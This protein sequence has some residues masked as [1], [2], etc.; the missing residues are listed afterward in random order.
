M[1][2]F[3]AIVVNATPTADLPSVVPARRV[4]L[5]ESNVRNAWTIDQQAAH[6]IGEMGDLPFEQRAIDLNWLF[7]T[8][9]GSFATDDAL[10]ECC[11]RGVIPWWEPSPGHRRPYS[12]RSFGSMLDKVGK[13]CQHIGGVRYVWCE[14]GSD[15]AGRLTNEGLGN[16]FFRVWESPLFR[17][18]APQRM[19]DVPDR[20]LRNWA[21]DATAFRKAINQFNDY[22]LSIVFE[23]TMTCLRSVGILGTRTTLICPYSYFTQR[24]PTPYSSNGRTTAEKQASA[25][26]TCDYLLVAGPSLEQQFATAVDKCHAMPH[27]FHKIN[28]HFPGWTPRLIGELVRH[29]SSVCPGVVLWFDPSNSGYSQAYI[30][31]VCQWVSRSVSPVKVDPDTLAPVRGGDVVTGPWSMSPSRI[32]QLSITGTN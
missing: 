7:A 9:A 6:V 18:H 12:D 23:S 3:S 1:N 31:D 26:A 11:E 16:L 14:M 2:D 27:G 22:L 15:S 32:V 21:L 24:W 29:C 13:A 4:D 30:D 5:G 8:W 17:A 28:C 19:F 25:D 10:V 20:V